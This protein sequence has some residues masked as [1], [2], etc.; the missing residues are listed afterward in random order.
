MDTEGFA[1]ARFAAK[2]GEKKTFERAFAEKKGIS[3]GAAE[4]RLKEVKRAP[5][6][7]KPGGAAAAGRQMTLDEAFRGAGN[8]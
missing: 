6:G 7:R 2:G 8:K 3:M 1:A 4:A 5:S